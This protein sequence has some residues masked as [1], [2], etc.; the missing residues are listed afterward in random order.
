MVA[1]ALDLDVLVVQEEPLVRIELQLADSKG[2]VH[3]VLDSALVAQRGDDRVER[4]SR[5]VVRRLLP[6]A[7]GLEVGRGR[8][9]ARRDIGAALVDGSPLRIEDLEGEAQAR[10]GQSGGCAGDICLDR[11]G[12]IGG[13]FGCRL[14]S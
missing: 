9:R 1:H 11:D 5:G 3:R 2:H 13:D 7:G 10:G 4:G 12:C 6:E 8:G 14:L